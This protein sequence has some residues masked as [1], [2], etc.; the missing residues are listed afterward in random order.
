MQFKIEACVTLI[1]V[2]KRTLGWT[3]VASTLSNHCFETVEAEV[4][5]GLKKKSKPES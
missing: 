3:V 5:N 1:K 2:F 4:T